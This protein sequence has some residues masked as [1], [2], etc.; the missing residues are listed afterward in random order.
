MVLSLGEGDPQVWELNRGAR[1]ANLPYYSHTQIP[2]R[3]G[4]HDTGTDFRVTAGLGRGAR[5]PS[6]K[7]D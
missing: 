5:T 7:T 3:R 6:E 1:S 2:D 4:I